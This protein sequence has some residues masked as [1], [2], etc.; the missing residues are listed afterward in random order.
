LS[1][2]VLVTG[3]AG[4]IGSHLAERLL[5]RGD[6]V[7]GLDNL[8]DCYDVRR[9]RSNIEEV[10]AL[11]GDPA[12]IEFVEGDIRDL[13]LTPAFVRGITGLTPSL[14]LPQWRGSV[15]QSTR[16]SCTST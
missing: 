8:D 9:K 2:T 4:F 10:L 16:R 14:T 3:F 7:V 5:E 1:K 11:A 15:R 12:R 13:G 6:T